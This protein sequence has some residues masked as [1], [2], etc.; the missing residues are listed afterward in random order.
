[1]DVERQIKF[2]SRRK[3]RWKILVRSEVSYDGIGDEIMRSLDAS[4]PGHHPK[5]FRL[6]VP[7]EPSAFYIKLYAA[8]AGAGRIKDFFRDSKAL[9]ALK[10]SEALE[11]LGFNVPPPLAAG[12]ERS[13][14]ALGRAFLVTREIVAQ[15]LIQVLRARFVP[16]LDKSAVKRKRQW[17]AQ[18]A[19][20]VRRLHQNGYVHGDLVAS[21][22]FVGFDVDD[23]AI[24][25]L[26]D[27]DRTRHYPRGMPHRLW[28][29]NLVQLNRL[30]LP[31]V[32]LQD[33]MRFARAYLGKDHWGNTERRLVRWLERR[34]RRRRK[35]CEHIKA[36]VSFR[37]LMRW[38]GPFAKNL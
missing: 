27:H 7:G 12:E 36:K 2:E 20:E 38:N 3:G 1:L 31:G 37:E 14:L 32:S 34:T 10:Q 15:P 21:N 11:R 13:G 9:R 5:T 33:R 16:P 26:M 19:R 4:P 23:S 6:A 17:L 8:P 30:V 35:E 28:R 22:I 24:F 25:Y 29:R 18:L